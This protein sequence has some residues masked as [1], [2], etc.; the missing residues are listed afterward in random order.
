MASVPVGTPFSERIHLCSKEEK[1]G[2]WEWQLGISKVGYGKIKINGKTGLAH[3][4]SYQSFVGDIPNN[5]QVCHHCDN[6][7]C[8]NPNHLF[9]GTAKENKQDAMRKGRIPFGSNHGRAIIA[10]NDIAT[11]KERRRQGET[12]KAIGDSYGISLHAIW[13]I[14][15]GRNWRHV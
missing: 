5:L 10:E 3:R 8:V 2:C 4:V 13:S 9:L 11:I 6:R 7:K 14:V 1:N 12:Y 15:K